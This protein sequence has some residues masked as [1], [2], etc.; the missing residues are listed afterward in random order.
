MSSRT[1]ARFAKLPTR[2]LRP[3]HHNDGCLRRYTSCS[4]EGPPVPTW[5]KSE[6][7]AFS[8]ATV[9]RLKEQ[10]KRWNGTL[11]KANGE[12]GPPTDSVDR[13]MSP[14]GQALYKKF[15]CQDPNNADEKILNDEGK[16]WKRA[17]EMDNYAVELIRAH[18]GS[19]E[20]EE[21]YKSS[22]NY[23]DVGA[24]SSNGAVV[25]LGAGVFLEKDTPGIDD[26]SR[27]KQNSATIT[28]VDLR[29]VANDAL[30]QFKE[31]TEARNVAVVG[32]PGT[33]KTRGGLTYALQTL[34]W[35]GETVLRIGYK[36]KRVYAFLPNENGAYEVWSTDILFWD[37]SDIAASGTAYALVDPAEGE[38]YTSIAPCKTLK[39]ASNNAKKHYENFDKFGKLLIAAMPTVNEMLAMTPVLWNEKT[40]PIT[41]NAFF[42]GIEAKKDEVR[43]RC[44]LVGCSPRAVFSG[45]HFEKSLAEIIKMANDVAKESRTKTLANL[46]FGERTFSTDKDASS[47]TSRL[48]DINPVESSRQ[49]PLLTLKPL[50]SYLWRLEGEQ[51]VA[52]FDG[53]RAFEFEDLCGMLIRS[54]TVGETQL[55]AR[56]LV[57][58]KSEDE[59]S[60]VIREMW[61]EG[62][63][64]VV[65]YGKNYPVLD[66]ATCRYAW[67]NAKVGSK[68][69][70]VKA[71]AFITLMLKLELAE[72]VDGKLVMK[73]EH[74]NAKKI[75]RA[76]V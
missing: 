33:G 60:K 36:E 18:Q 67:F 65:A 22:G 37:I 7:A 5:M 50:V 54:A 11:G 34:L 21:E 44:A 1:L 12:D 14:E 48:Y 6:R 26:D 3:V 76:H 45:D 72:K 35:R 47:I 63:K 71:G 49:K 24:E 38:P 59:T 23:F 75:G 57:L 17:K 64:V 51:Q 55:P 32:Y 61:A 15:V 70:T 42:Q 39:F 46:Y 58:P 53:R 8:R 9:S 29:A 30:E 2:I 4:R 52:G 73:D 16:K 43:D 41:S 62:Q 68:K 66:F 74:K 69:P 56:T 27:R 20:L 10:T 25:H 28:R 13:K 19:L 31:P 40:T